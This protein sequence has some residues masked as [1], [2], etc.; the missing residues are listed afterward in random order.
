M[1]S[2]G[3][4]SG[5]IVAIGKEI[6]AARNRGPLPT[7]S[8]ARRD[9]PECAESKGIM[10]AIGMPGIAPALLYLDT[11]AG[12]A[13]QLAFGN[14]EP[15]DGETAIL[16]YV[17]REARAQGCRVVL[18]GAGGDVALAHGSY[19]MRLIRK[20]Q[21]RLAVREIVALSRFWEDP[22]PVTDLALHAR[23]AL[24]PE[25]IKQQLRPFRQRR[26]DRACLRRSLISPKFAADVCIEERFGRMREILAADRKSELA[27]ERVGAFRPNMT[28]GR[29]RYAR[30]AASVATE[31]RDPFMDKR[32]IEYSV[33]LPGKLRL[34]DGWPKWILRDVM[35]DRLPDEVRWC[36]GKPH[37]GFRFNA[38]V[39][40]AAYKRGDL[41][42]E[43]LQKDLQ[44]YV[45]PAALADAW[46]QF[47]DGTDA[48]PVH[49]AYVLSNW[50]REHAD[51][52]VVSARRFG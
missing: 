49:T 17:Y 45:D 51:R 39:S 40:M 48:E 9:D 27:V 7:I 1:L 31:A 14:E 22:S 20:G 11:V 10:A 15:F 43:Q 19:V 4:D 34:R 33:H 44:G 26:D 42:L 8:A 21:V 6:M 30:V 12:V 2:G 38:A 24:V 28:A 3:V 47:L 29:E 36:R 25:F 5:S 35:A 41:G 18:D 50:L 13:D 32:V 16:K 23:A 52:S 46:R 37:L